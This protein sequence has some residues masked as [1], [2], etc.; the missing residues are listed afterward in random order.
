VISSSQA[1]GTRGR[2]ATK[3]RF[4]GA[5]G[6]LLAREGFNALGVNAVAEEAGVDK[7]LIYRYFGGMDE[8]LA[9]FGR[10][11]DFWPTLDEVIGDDVSEL[12]KFTVAERWAIGLSRYAHSLR[13]RPVTREILAWELIEQ[14]DLIQ[15]LRK[16]REE[17]FEELMSHFPDDPDAAD[18]DLVAT[19]LVLVGAIHYFVVLGR[20]QTDFSGIEI[21]TDAGWGHLDTVISTILHRTLKTPD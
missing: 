9:A 15:I 7:V 13:S 21:G 2:E 6:S 14:N 1:S 18:G 20:L 19:V 3:L 10:S 5:V 16:V 11:G 12:M 8:L 17:W 4:I